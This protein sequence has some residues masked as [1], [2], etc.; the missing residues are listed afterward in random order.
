MRRDDYSL[1]SGCPPPELHVGSDAL[2]GVIDHGGPGLVVYGHVHEDRG[3]WKRGSSVLANATV[4]DAAAVPR[5]PAMAFEF[6]LD[7]RVWRV[8]RG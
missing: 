2:L 6:D 5:Y 8:L 4:L 1:L 3:H 7:R